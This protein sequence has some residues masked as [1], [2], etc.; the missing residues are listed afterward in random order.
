MAAARFWRLAGLCPALVG[1]DLSLSEIELRDGSGTRLDTSATLSC[2]VAPASGTLADLQDGS[3]ASAV[4]WTAASMMSPLFAPVWEFSTAVDVSAVALYGPARLL[5]AREFAL[6]QSSDGATWSDAAP[7]PFACRYADAATPCVCALSGQGG[8]YGARLLT[9][10]PL[11]YWPLDETSGTTAAD[12]SGNGFNGAIQNGPGLGAAPIRQG[13][14]RSIGFNLGGSGTQQVYVSTATAGSTFARLDQPGSS[15]T[16]CMWFKRTA[17]SNYNILIASWENYYSGPANFRIQA[18]SAQAPDNVNNVPFTT[19]ASDV[20]FLAWRKSAAAKYYDVTLNGQKIGQ[21]GAFSD[22]N[23]KNG[24]QGLFFPAAYNI[25]YYPACGYMSDVAI[26][27][28]ALSDA[29]LAELYLMGAY[30][31]GVSAGLAPPPMAL[32]GPAVSADILGETRGDVQV[33][34]PPQASTGLDLEFGGRARITGDVG[35]KGAGGA[36]DTMTKSRVRL[37][38]ARD[39]LLARETWSQL[40]GG[41]FAFDDLDENTEFIALAQDGS[42]SYRPVA[43]DRVVPEVP[44]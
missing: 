13:S 17:S 20:M 14:A 31:M 32:S 25:S 8:S 6:Q 11:A 34:A 1:G 22:T 27:G 12:L 3:S 28:R 33:I 15:F 44:S 7:L 42:G 39:G 37:L 9:M 24:T 35:I 18:G 41:T 5:F 36:P 30:D 23:T 43:A 38:R 26:F 21:S 40:P 19:P 10:A 16:V 29:E 4:T 2:A